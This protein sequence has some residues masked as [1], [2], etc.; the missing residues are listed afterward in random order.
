MSR[1]PFNDD[2][3]GCKPEM[4]VMVDPLTNSFLPDDHPV[5]KAIVEVWKKT[6]FAERQVFHQVC[7][8][9]SCDTN[10]LFIFQGLLGRIQKAISLCASGN[11]RNIAGAGTD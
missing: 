3:P 7:C 2:C 5:M 10:D 6:T 4:L 11:L 9:K 1:K 8:Q